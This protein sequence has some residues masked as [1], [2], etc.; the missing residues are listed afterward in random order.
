VYA[1]MGSLSVDE[2]RFMAWR[3]IDGKEKDPLGQFGELETLVRGVFERE[4]LLDYLRH[5]IVFEDDGGLSK[6]IAAYHQFHAVRAVVARVL[7]ASALE[8]MARVAWCGIRKVR[9]KAWR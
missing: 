3:T 6:K 9:A 8:A 2:E 4:Y 5:F 1:R 7:E